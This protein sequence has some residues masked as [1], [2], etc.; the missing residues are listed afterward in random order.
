MVAEKLKKG[1][2]QV[3]TRNSFFG[4]LILGLEF[5]E[6]NNCSTIGIDYKGSCVYNK[7]FIEGLTI[8]ELITI[9]A[10]ELLHQVLLHH[11]RFMG[12]NHQLSNISED[13]CINSML[14]KEH[15]IFPKISIKDDKGNT[16]EK[17]NGLVPNSNDEMELNFD[18]CKVIIKDCSTKSAEMI[19]EEII[20]EL[21]NNSSYVEDEGDGEGSEGDD[22]GDGKGN[23]DN[24]GDKYGDGDGNGEGSEKQRL[25]KAIKELSKRVFDEHKKVD[26]TKMSK[27]QIREA[28]K[29]IE[30]VIREA[31]E[32]SRS[33]GDTPFGIERLWGELHE[34]K[35]NWK[36]LLQRYITEMLPYDQSWRNFGK[37]TYGTGVYTPM[38]LREQIDVMVAIDLSG[39]I[40]NKD[41][42]DFISEI[43]GIAKQFKNRINMKIVTHECEV[44]DEFNVFNE[45]D[46]RNIKI[47]GGGGTSFEPTIN[48][49]KQNHKTT[50]CLIWLT[51]GEGEIELDKQPFKIVW[52]LT[53]NGDEKLLNKSGDVLRLKE[54]VARDI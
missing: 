29:N 26:R 41:L 1:K 51:D 25:K 22:E 2:V 16:I 23:S 34:E 40:S 19:Y 24:D 10:H 9:I 14:A 38:T 45:D 13:I 31:L 17:I 52:T 54:I 12:K 49:I 43:T 46:I 11:F 50:K 21:K 32:F 53:E 15:Y 33:R 42:T 4:R 48:Y 30:G 5:K 36:I 39:S 20:R 8:D 3:Q 27:K 6:D 44:L 28:K 18:I 35:F 47:K 37:K 7:S